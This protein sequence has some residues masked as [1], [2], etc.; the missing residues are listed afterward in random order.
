MRP[1]DFNLRVD[2]RVFRDKNLRQFPYSPFVL[3]LE[4]KFCPLAHRGSIL[5]KVFKNGPSKICEDSLKK[6]EVIWS[7]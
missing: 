6:F 4:K 7:A 1:P 3:A 2:T 5:E